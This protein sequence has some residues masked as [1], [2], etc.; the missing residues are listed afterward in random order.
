MDTPVLFNIFFTCI[1]AIV[2]S[3]FIHTSRSAS[4]ELYEENQ[5]VNIVMNM[6]TSPSRRLE[7]AAALLLYDP[8]TQKYQDPLKYDLHL[9]DSSTQRF[10]NQLK[11]VLQT[12]GDTALNAVLK[13]NALIVLFDGPNLVGN[14]VF[15]PLEG[16]FPQA[17]VDDVVYEKYIKWNPPSNIISA[18]IPNGYKLKFE[19][20]ESE[21]AKYIEDGITKTFVIAGPV[22]RMVIEK[23]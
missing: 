8:Q 11:S 15:L 16:Y 4:R 17:V 7:I 6:D 19:F 13:H 12:V 14:I 5:A 18:I 9:S 1:L 21:D 2:I 3:V 20:V 22:H 23:T 10:K